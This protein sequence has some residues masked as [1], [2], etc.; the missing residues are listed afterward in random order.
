MALVCKYF[1]ADYNYKFGKQFET[2]GLFYFRSKLDI[3][4]LI[5]VCLSEFFYDAKSLRV[6]FYHEKKLTTSL[7]VILFLKWNH[8]YGIIENVTEV[9]WGDN[10]ITNTFI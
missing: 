9:L 7:H 5:S 3:F 1:Y 4:I 6:H 2:K 8:D 10:F